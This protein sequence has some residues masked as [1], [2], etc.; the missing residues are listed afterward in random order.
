MMTLYKKGFLISSEKEIVP[1]FFF[2]KDEN[3]T[4]N[5][6]VLSQINLIS[7]N[8]SQIKLLIDNVMRVKDDFHVEFE[9]STNM[10]IFKIFENNVIITDYIFDSPDI[11][12][13]IDSFLQIIEDKNKFITDLNDDIILQKIK[14]ALMNIKKNPIWK[15]GKGFNIIDDE[16]LFYMFAITQ[17]EMDKIDVE[18]YISTLRF[19]PVCP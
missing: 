8:R 19:I 9:T 6:D 15:E 18:K 14:N 3:S 2:E 11:T 17:Y 12:I 16:N 7:Y 13:S 10:V 1:Y 5:I 4:Y